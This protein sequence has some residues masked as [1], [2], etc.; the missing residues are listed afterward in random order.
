MTPRLSARLPLPI[1]NATGL[2]PHF[3]CE[4]IRVMMRDLYD[5]KKLEKLSVNQKKYEEYSRESVSNN[6]DSETGNLLFNIRQL[7]NWYILGLHPFANGG[8]RECCL[9]V[10]RVEYVWRDRGG[11][12]S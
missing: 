1:A 10:S 6:R 5:D 7:G 12:S 2:E 8:C 4:E 9:E 11:L 3:V